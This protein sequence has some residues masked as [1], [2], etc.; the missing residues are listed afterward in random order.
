MDFISWDEKMSVGVK[1]F[2]NEH[3]QLVT[4]LNNL[5][6]ASKIGKS[7]KTIE[8]ILTN[9]IKYTVI[10][11]KHE[12]DYMALYEYADY[13]MHKKEHGDLTAQVTDF[14]VR[15]KSGKASFNFELLAFLHDWLINHILGSDK[16]YKNFF[17][18]KGV[19]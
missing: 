2:D 1:H 7:P 11:F 5:N 18:S 4:L 12:E 10:H 9:L 3:K 17:N 15:L 8:E 6:Q 16:D 13:E 19:E 14:H